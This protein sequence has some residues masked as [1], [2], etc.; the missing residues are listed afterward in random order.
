MNALAAI[1]HLAVAIGLHSEFCISCKRSMIPREIFAN[2]Y[3]DGPVL[4]HACKELRNRE[5]SAELEEVQQ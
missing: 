4:C 3:Y 5:I 2:N 1:D